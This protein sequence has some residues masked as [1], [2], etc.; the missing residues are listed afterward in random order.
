MTHP[1]SLSPASLDELRLPGKLYQAIIESSDDAI[2]AQSLDGVILAWN[3]GAE[4]LYGYAAA[5]AVGRPIDFIVAPDRQGEMEA[6]Y[7]RVAR[8]ERV[9]HFETRRVTRDGSV[10]DVSI[11][12]SPIKD[13]A[14]N[15]VAAS[16]IGRDITERKR[17]E[18][19]REL[20]A[21]V[22]RNSS[23]GIAITDAIGRIQRVNPSFTAITGYAAEEVIGQTPSVL[24]SDRHAPEFYQNM[25]AQLL[26][27]GQWSGE[28]WNR[29]KSGEAYPEW[30]TISAV[31]NA[32]G[33]TTHFISIFHDITETKRQ[34]EAIEYLANHDALTGLPN[35]L[36]LDD[37]LG[38]SLG[39]AG[40]RGT[41]LAALF[42]DLDNFKHINDS[43]GHA[44]GDVLLQELA[45]RLLMA[46]RS[47]D[48]VSRRGGDEF[49]IILPEIAG[50]QDAVHVCQRIFEALATPFRL[51][52]HEL[53]TTV[54]IGIALYPDDAADAGRLIKNADMA[55]YQAKNISG[56]AFHFFAPE[57]DTQAQ[58]RMTLE[59]RLRRAMELKEL[60]LYY[61]PVVDM[62]T[63]MIRGAEA[64]IRWWRDGSLISPDEFIPLAEET[65]IIVPL[66]AWVL[67]TACRQARAW[68]AMGFASVTMA[69]NISVKQ[70][71]QGNF[72][73][74]V[75]EALRTYALAP[76]LLHLELTESALMTNLVAT[77]ERLQSIRDLGVKIMLDDF[78]TGYSSMAYLKRLPVDGLKIDRS[79]IR[80]IPGDADSRAITAAVVGLA[81]GLGLEL[82]AEGVETPEQLA[83]LRSQ[84]CRQ[85]QGY[86]A[87]RPVPAAEFE[88]L[89]RAGQ[90]LV[91]P[92]RAR[93]RLP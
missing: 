32:E 91:A 28:I 56:N 90:P 79:F 71:G 40:R 84:G 80:E 25:W 26:G 76:A 15:V 44:V 34:Q 39:Q 19:D 69:V 65:G 82:V 50:P 38:V 73:Q 1:K 83:Y 23:E 58:R 14:G 67:A 66:G 45:G 41:K 53:F 49:I 3:S 33:E 17:T 22:F 13:D 63:G 48:T 37:R 62:E 85:F 36:L 78:G 87:S 54:S 6:L 27:Q 5:E 52:G 21:K 72:T 59:L 30:L 20:A 47:A 77:A 12:V 60:E 88:G 42:L 89:L 2:L 18:A 75:A 64:L 74:A 51:H 24:K 4:K 86:L 11:S 57:M 55:M 8:G 35:R 9:E 29:R 93:L 70:F 31:K 43:L 16:A 68:Q 92:G 46:V 7:A 81:R 61:Q 10:I